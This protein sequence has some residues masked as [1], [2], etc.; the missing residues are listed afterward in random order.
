MSP[1]NTHGWTT[2]KSRNDDVTF[3]VIS[4]IPSKS[5][6]SKNNDDDNND[7]NNDND[8]DNDNN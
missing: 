6:Y 5:A 2:R 7:N 4:G 1:S 3:T 8:N